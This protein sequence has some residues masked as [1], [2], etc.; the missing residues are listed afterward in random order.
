VTLENAILGRCNTPAFSRS[1]D[2]FLTSP[3][4]DWCVCLLASAITRLSLNVALA[5]MVGPGRGATIWR[6]A[7]GYWR[8]RL[9]Q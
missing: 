3:R 9:L 5:I 2:P 7:C 8:G 6:G 1:Q 4:L